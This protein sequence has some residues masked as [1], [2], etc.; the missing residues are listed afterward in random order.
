MKRALL[1]LFVF[2]FALTACSNEELYE[3]LL[4]DYQA[5][6]EEQ[7]DTYREINE[8]LNALSSDVVRSAV[9]I[10][11][12]GET[13]QSGSGV[14]FD[15]DR[16]YYYALT[17]NHVA[18]QKP[19]KSPAYRIHDYLGNSYDASLVY[20][21]SDYDLAVLK[22]RKSDSDLRLIDFSD[23]NLEVGEHVAIIGFPARQINAIT[24]GTVNGYERIE[25][26]DVD[27]DIVSIDFDVMSMDAPVKGGSSGSLVVNERYELSGILFAGTIT[28]SNFTVS[29][30]LPLNEVMSF[31]RDYEKTL[32]SGDDDA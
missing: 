6:L 4:G 23:R 27:P 8:Y 32:E 19:S 16:L 31:I 3:E 30:A 1:L 7:Q 28:G 10:Y 5:H 20:S 21:D 11:N 25:I 13:T 9:A 18:Y 17:N 2:L 24:M 12:L 29:Y 14:I 26:S 22:F 15:E